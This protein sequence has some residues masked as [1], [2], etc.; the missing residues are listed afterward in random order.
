MLKPIVATK[1]VTTA[2]TQIQSTTNTALAVTSVYYE[3]LASNTGNIY[4]GDADVS[5]T[6]YIAKLAAGEGFTIAIDNNG[7]RA[8]TGSEIQL[9]SIWIDS[10]VNGEK[11]QMTYIQRSAG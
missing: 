8:T 5:S 6:L 2:G 7:G 1:T 10:S 9:S 4:I 11:V 3:A